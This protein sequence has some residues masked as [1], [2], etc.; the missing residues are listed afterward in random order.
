MQNLIVSLQS[1]KSAS[2][3][4]ASL[5]GEEKNRGLSK[6]ADELW[7]NRQGILEANVQDVLEADQNGISPAMVDRLTLNEI[8]WKSVVEDLRKVIEL[9]DPIGKSIDHKILPNGLDVSRQRVPL[10]VLAVIYEARPN[11]T[12]DVIGLAIKSGNAVVLRG[13]KETLRTNQ[14]IIQVIENALTQ[15]VIPVE[16]VLFID[17]PDREILMQLMKRYD[18][19]DMLIPRGGAGLH[20]FCRENSMIPVITGGIGI[21]HLFV[22]ESANLEKAFDVIRNAKIQRPTVCNAL[23]TVLI[24]KQIAES[25]I[26]I[27][28]EQLRKDGV[29]F[30]ADQ[31]A[32]QSLVRAEDVFLANEDDFDKEWLSLKLGIKVVQ[33]LDEA[34]RHIQLHSTG[35]SDGILTED[36]S[37]A[38]R[39]VQQV[40][41]AAVYVN[42]STR[43]TDGSALGLG[44]EIAISTQKLH[45][46]GPMGLEELT[47]YK[48]VIKGNYHSRE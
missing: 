24:H 26:P 14:A 13:G 47:T 30:Y 5:S 20:Q 42:A 38:E 37:N 28:V 18:L 15:T 1:L 44:A 32:F 17:N 6:I 36:K 23:D 9:P 7:I 22:D 25:F 43:F 34:I 4:L 2:R 11:V 35:H 16:A 39:F 21:C 45:A 46:R 3:I 8:R 40:D 10:G 29:V 41:S 12:V 27:L 31:A 19:I 48:W 33:G